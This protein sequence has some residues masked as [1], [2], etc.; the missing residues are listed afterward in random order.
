MQGNRRGQSQSALQAVQSRHD[1]I[2]K[3]ERQIIELGQ[4]FEDLNA[5]VQIQEPIVAQINEQSEVVHTNVNQAN[6]QLDGA[7]KKARSAN[8]KKW[9]CLGIGSKCSITEAKPALLTD[10]SLDYRGHRYCCCLSDRTQAAL[11]DRRSFTTHRS[12]HP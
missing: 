6:T 2:Q 1:A 7:I 5:T 4:L 9:I 8:R 12:R 3:I 10:F 11:R